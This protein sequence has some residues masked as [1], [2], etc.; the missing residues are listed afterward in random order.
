MSR[1]TGWTGNAMVVLLPGMDGSGL[2]F[3]DF[4]EALGPHVDAKV[5][6]Y[7]RDRAL[8]YSELTALAR[9]ELPTDQPFVLLGESFSGPIAVALAAGRPPGLRALVLVCSFVRSPISAPAVLRRMLAVFPVHRVPVRL[10]AAVLLGKFATPRLRDLLADAVAAVK[11]KVWHSRL[12]AV[13]STDVEKLLS[14]IQVPLLYLRARQDRVVP[15]RASE[16]I[17][18]ALS[19]ARIVDLDGPH[20]MLQAKPA[21]SAA[22]LHRLLRELV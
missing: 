12:A 13:L 20:F 6:A 17:V 4:I 3:G 16:L 15:R 10:A 7:P 8:G 9:A 5:V 2:L 11:P 14:E 19:R 22:Q 21:E 18:R 1:S